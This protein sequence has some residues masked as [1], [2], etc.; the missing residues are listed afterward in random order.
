MLALYVCL[1]PL[2]AVFSLCANKTLTQ[3]N[4][5]STEFIKQSPSYIYIYI[6]IYICIHIHIYMICIHIYIYDM[7]IYICIYIHPYMPS[8][9]PIGRF[10]SGLQGPRP[11]AQGSAAGTACA[12]DGM[13][14]DGCNPLLMVI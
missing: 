14:F 6:Y 12:A 7:Y 8:P 9:F 13:W 3:K 5:F 2:Y 11:T 10:P 4:R 1:Q